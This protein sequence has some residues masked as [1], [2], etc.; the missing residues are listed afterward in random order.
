[1]RSEILTVAVFIA[2]L[3]YLGYRDVHDREL[4]PLLATIPWVAATLLRLLLPPSGGWWGRTALLLLTLAILFHE[5]FPSGSATLIAGAISL[6]TFS[7]SGTLILIT[8]WTL[9]FTLYA[10]G[11]W[12]GADAKVMMVLAAVWPA[13]TMGIAV[14]AGVLV[15]GVIALVRR[16]GR[17]APFAVRST[18]QEGSLPE[19]MTE[20]ER[21][22]LTE[23]PTLPWIALGAST[24]LI[25]GLLGVGAG[26]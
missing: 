2:W 26:G 19:Q 25:L 9:S 11:I 17:A 6:S 8:L 7:G 15:G 21:A 4:P 18:I 5:R 13:W 23:M 16:Y 1:M 3:A 10:L 24:Y 22:Q 14:G 20:E 12:G